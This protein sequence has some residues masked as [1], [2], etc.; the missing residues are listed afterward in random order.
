M[1]V[2]FFCFSNFILFLFC[3]LTF[4]LFSYV[5]QLNI[6]VFILMLFLK[7]ILL[8]ITILY[9]WFIL[10][11]IFTLF[12][13]E[14]SSVYYHI[15]LIFILILFMR[16]ILKLYSYLFSEQLFQWH[17]YSLM[18]ENYSLVILTLFRSCSFYSY[19]ITVRIL[20]PPPPATPSKQPKIKFSNYCQVMFNIFVGWPRVVLPV[21]PLFDMLST[22]F[23]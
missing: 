6:L 2:L 16:V 7:T 4:I 21:F 3:I 19:V 14:N 15:I 22:S 18:S 1:P 11:N 20:V 9:L 13:F 10:K 5:F 23:V 17:Y 8:F 12:S